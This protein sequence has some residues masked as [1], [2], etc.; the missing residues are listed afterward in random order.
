M[1][2][3]DT[4]EFLIT[5]ESGYSDYSDH[6]NIAH[7]D[8]NPHSDSEHSDHSDHSNVGHS[9]S[10]PHNDSHSDLSSPHSNTTAH[11]DSNYNQYNDWNNGS[12]VHADGTNCRVTPNYGDFSEHIDSSGSDSH[13]DTYHHVICVKVSE[14]HSDHGDSHTNWSNHSNVAHSD[15]QDH[16][17]AAHEDWANHNDTHT[18]WN[19][20]NDI[21]QK[22]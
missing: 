10:Y 21:G 14:E 15:W 11:I 8:S 6:G 20:H 18:D 4:F 2:A 7:N 1:G 19:D 5:R 3:K 17:E 9:D 12:Y 13:N 22:G 16:N